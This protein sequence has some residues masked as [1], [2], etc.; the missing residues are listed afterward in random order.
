MTSTSLCGE[1]V[2][3]RQ[4]A[5][6]TVQFSDKQVLIDYINFQL[7]LWNT[8]D[9]IFLKE[10]VLGFSLA[11]SLCFCHWQTFSFMLNYKFGAGVNSKS[12]CNL[13]VCSCLTYHRLDVWKFSALLP[14]GLSKASH[15]TGRA[16]YFIQTFPSPGA[17]TFSPLLAYRQCSTPRRVDGLY[18]FFHLL[19][20]SQQSFP[21]SG[22]YIH[23]LIK[24]HPQSI[25][26]SFYLW[27]LLNFS[28][29]SGAQSCSFI[30]TYLPP[31]KSTKTN[32]EWRLK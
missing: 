5:L 29:Y 13:S 12:K 32:S 9:Q 24:T 2:E 17:W 25:H 31:L 15:R 8:L 16:S 7:C 27:L 22:P 26:W 1:Y 30:R 11:F 28:N 6:Q 10:W 4:S 21:E 18:F 3:K 19:I 23:V 20:W 14:V